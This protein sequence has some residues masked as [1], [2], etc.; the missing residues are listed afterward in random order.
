MA[1]EN[2]G[3]NLGLV[4]QKDHIRTKSV[5]AGALKVNGG[6]ILDDVVLNTG[7]SHLLSQDASLA[8][9][10]AAAD[11]AEASS[12]LSGDTSVALSGAQA[13]A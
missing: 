7:L 2:N 12:R 6:G 5:F 4:I 9:A 13:D 8:T 1:V 3:K 11:T 10:F